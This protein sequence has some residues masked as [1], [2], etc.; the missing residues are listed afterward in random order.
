M[1]A[2]APQGNQPDNSMGIIWII[3]AI[4]IA[5]GFIWLAFKKQIV[6]FYFK[7]KLFEITL[8]SYFTPNL[9]DVRD[10]ILSSDPRAFTFDDVLRVGNA[11]G[12]YLRIPFVLLMLILAALVYF[13]NTARVFK[14][15]YGMRD[16]A[17][18]EKTNW[19]QITPVVNLDLL[20][21]DID[22]GPWAM[23]LTPVQFC[24]RHNLIEERKKQPNENMS[25]KE[26]MQ[27][28]AVLKRGAAT[29]VFI[30]QLG[31][32][33][34]GVDKLPLHMRAL[35]A[36][37]AA[38]VN[39]DTKS[40]TDLLAK[41]SVSSATKLDFTGTEPLL[42]KHISSKLV[43]EVMNSHGYVLT[44]MA[45]ML[46]AARMDGVQASADFLWLKPVDRRLWYMLNTVGRQT[47]FVEVAGPFAHWIAEKEY[48]KKLMIPMVEEATK[49]LEVALKEIIYKP[50]EKEV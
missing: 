13:G 49:A 40:A 45:A 42:K 12:D 9:N 26:R 27:I 7:I 3:S 14:R 6:G 36:V 24:K 28:E 5:A 1:A 19:P 11:V 4:F 25:H 48:G 34:Q 47:P 21:T 18:L 29:K 16:L 30:V 22:K 15:A 46:Q 41:I 43:Q 23:A 39:N 17:Q 37:F 8:I 20:G 32:T 33:W 10:T 38:R 31:P 50:D 44:V 35:F 2:A